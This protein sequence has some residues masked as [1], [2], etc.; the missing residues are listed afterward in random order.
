MHARGL[1]FSRMTK[2]SLELWNTIGSV[3]TFVVI[4]ATAIAAIIQLRHMRSNIQ[5]TAL[6]ELR[7]TIESEH[8][9]AAIRFV[10]DELPKILAD[11]QQRKRLD[12][13]PLDR[14]LQAI[15]TVCNFFENVGTLVKHEIIEKTIALDMWA[16]VITINWDRLAPFVAQRRRFAGRQSVW[17][18]RIPYRLGAR[19]DA[20]ASRWRLPQRRGP[21]SARVSGHETLVVQRVR[22]RVRG[23]IACV[24][25]AHAVRPPGSTRRFLLA[26]FV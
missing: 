9:Q 10:A 20:A 16:L 1:F 26:G 7:E 13:Y 19:V 11:P 12:Q 3:G 18:F 21:D 22:V 15:S 8:Y 5:I 17:E 4:A 2:M 24:Y 23:I 6:N 14:D 25:M